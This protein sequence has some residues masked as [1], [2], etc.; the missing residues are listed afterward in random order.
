MILPKDAQVAGHPVR[1]VQAALRE[2]ARSPA[3]TRAFFADQRAWRARRRLRDPVEVAEAEAATRRAAGLL[4]DALAAEGLLVSGPGRGFHLSERGRAILGATV[5]AGYRQASAAKALEGFLERAR[6]LESPDAGHPYRVAVAILFGSHAAGKPRVGDVDLLVQLAPREAGPAPEAGPWPMRGTW[7]YLKGGSR[8]LRLVPADAA[9]LEAALRG[10][11][12][13]VYAS[14]PVRRLLGTL[15]LPQ[16]DM[17]TA[18]TGEPS[19]PS[20]RKG[21]AT[22]A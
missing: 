1:Q 11:H 6:G 17:S 19:A 8:I 20:M 7:V 13:V 3:T 21:S 15:L 22:K 9:A 16:T 4:W 12:R 14:E 18:R 5:G 2:L 10:P